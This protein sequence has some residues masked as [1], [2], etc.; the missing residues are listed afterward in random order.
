MKYRLYD[1]LLHVALVAALPFFIIKMLTVKKYR[2]G[3][4]ERFGCIGLDKLNRLKGGQIVWFHAISVG[5][6]KAVVPVL[7]LFKES[8]PDMKVVF[9]TV[10][11]TGNRCALKECSGLVDA[12]IYFPL[13]LSWVVNRTI[14]LVNPRALIVVEKEIWPNMILSLSRR[15]VP[16]IIVNGTISE[17]SFKRFMRFG[18][19]FRE[20]FSA[21]GYFAARTKEDCERAIR[22]GVPHERAGNVGN[23]KY[24]MAPP[25]S[26]SEHRVRLLSSMALLP[27][28][29]V[30]VA[31]STH[32]GEEEMILRAYAGLKPRFKTLKLVLVPRHPERFNEVE[33]LIRNTGSAFCRRSNITA[34]AE[35]I[36]LDTVGELMNVYSIAAIA[37][38]GGSLVKGVG[39][40]NLLEPALHAKP[41]IY[42]GHLTTYL[43]MAELLEANGG[44]I[45]VP[46]ETSLEAVIAGL[47]SDGAMR[48]AMGEA[49]KKAVEANRGAARRTASIIDGLLLPFLKKRQAKK[50]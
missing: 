11:M 13:D 5:E 21:L 40:H 27:E 3:L 8:H 49:A 47:L 1:I 7:R 35:I 10:T 12:L 18:F 39:G 6:T 14:R 34:G 37:F 24:D 22:A 19:L 31:G 2:E 32:K 44:G 45:R 29:L 28:D 50:P 36:L 38:V 30:I 26:T 9:S 20:V 41:V 16:V 42:G 23:I 33:A 46:D 48:A 25:D 17:R 43:G 4:A 15:A